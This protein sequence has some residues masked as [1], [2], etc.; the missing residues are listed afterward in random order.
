MKQLSSPSKTLFAGLSA[1]V[2]LTALAA[3]MMGQGAS[4]PV[5]SDQQYFVTAEGGKA[6]LWLREGT[7]LRAVGH[8]E[9]TECPDNG[10]DGHKHMEGGGHEHDAK[11]GDAHDHDDH[12][13]G[14]PSD[15]GVASIGGFTV[16]V[17]QEGGIAEGQDAAFDISITGGTGKPSV[18]RAWIGTQDAKG[19]LKSKAEGEGGGY[20]LHVE[21]PE[22]IPAAAKLWI[23]IDNAS[24]QK[25]LG[26][27]AL[28]R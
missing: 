24:G 5:K 6:H 14:K 25:A 4:Q 23:E 16:K 10:N 11:G 27:V 2:A 19:S 9:C 8:G 12:G 20:H 18:V 26:S 7:T 28:K 21:V 1:G 3:V 22:P 13:H 15:L 17:T